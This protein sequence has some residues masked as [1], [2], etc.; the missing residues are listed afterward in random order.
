MM[1]TRDQ[2]WVLLQEFTETDSLRKHALAV[3]PGFPQTHNEA[4]GSIPRLL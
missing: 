1:V 3:E 4:G 2:A